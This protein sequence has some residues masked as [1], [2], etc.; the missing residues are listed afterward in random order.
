MNNKA[1]QEKAQ[2]LSQLIHLTSE[3]YNNATPA[4]KGLLETLIGAGIWYLPSDR[5]ILYSGK[6]S[7]AAYVRL[8][9]D[10]STKLC[11]EHGHPRKVAGR[12]LYRDYD[13]QLD[14]NGDKLVALYIELYGKFN[15]VLK[16][17]NGKLSK[18]Q[19][20]EVFVDEVTAYQ[21]AG[22]ELVSVTYDEIEKLRKIYSNGK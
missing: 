6:I 17:E 2:V 22:I 4:Q 13:N 1:L 12:A 7:K 11:E 21:N 10:P 20:A 18:H 15:Y 3:L 8:M 9:S 19:R 5:K 14:P 16:E